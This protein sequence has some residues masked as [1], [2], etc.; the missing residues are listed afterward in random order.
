L[1][2]RHRGRLVTGF[3]FAGLLFG[4]LPSRCGERGFLCRRPDAP[5]FRSFSACR[6]FSFSFLAFFFA[7]L[8]PV[9]GHLFSPDHR[10]SPSL[11]Q[12]LRDRWEC[13]VSSFQ[14]AKRSKLGGRGFS[15]ESP[16][17]PL[18]ETPAFHPWLLSVAFAAVSGLLAFTRRRIFFF[19]DAP[20]FEPRGIDT[21]SPLRRD[22]F[23]FVRLFS[24]VRQKRFSQRP[25]LP[26]LVPAPGSPVSE[27]LYSRLTPISTL[28]L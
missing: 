16:L 17:F 8:Q 14:R 19:W 24:A 18:H 27:A 7:L 15:R 22:L 3:T 28:S 4:T 9:M 20:L 10:Y 25:D 2:F 23:L 6:D 26:F 12:N 13:R 5:L 1:V 21:S 11:R